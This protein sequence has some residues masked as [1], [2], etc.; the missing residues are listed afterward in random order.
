LKQWQDSGEIWNEVYELINAPNL[1]EKGLSSK[2]L[3]LLKSADGFE[4]LSKV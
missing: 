4:G 3:E 2:L 1:E